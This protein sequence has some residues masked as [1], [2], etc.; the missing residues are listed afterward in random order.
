MDNYVDRAPPAS[1]SERCAYRYHLT[2]Y[3]SATTLIF[4]LRA[5]RFL[6]LALRPLSAFIETH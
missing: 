4:R 3:A 5:V 1:A 6:L 2:P